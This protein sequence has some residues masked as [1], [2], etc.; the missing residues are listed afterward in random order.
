[1]AATISLETIHTLPGSSGSK[2]V[3]GR[4]SNTASHGRE[5]VQHRAGGF[6]F[7]GGKVKASAPGPSS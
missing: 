6:G 4:I 2:T 1:M 5:G 3:V 7:A